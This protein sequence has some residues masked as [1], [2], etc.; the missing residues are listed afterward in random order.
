MFIDDLVTAGGKVYEVGGTVR[1]R[2]L[3][4]K[5]KD[6]DLLI[7]GLTIETISAILKPYG[8]VTLVGKSFGVIKFSPHKD[9][10]MTIDIAI[11]RKEISTG[12]GHRDFKVD[13]DPD[14]PV[15]EDLGR[16]DFTVN[17]MAYDLAEKNFIDPFNGSDDLQ[18]GILRQ[19]F[20][21][22]FV[23]DPLRLLRAIQFSA[24]FALEIEQQTKE[25]MKDHA[26]LINTV[27]GERIIEELK[28]LMYAKKPSAG[29]ELMSEVGLLQ[30]VLP[31][32]EAIKGI[33]Q[34]KQKNDDVFKHT[35][36]VLDATRMDQAIDHEGNMELMFA[37][38]LHDIGKARTKRYSPKDK[39][40]VFYGHQ[41]VSARMARKILNRLKSQTIGVDPKVVCKLIEHHMFETKSFF[42]DKAIRRFIS[43]VG[44]DLIYKLIDL[45]LADN[46]GGKYPNGIKGVMRLKKRVTEEINRKAPFGPKDLAVNG[47]DLMKLGVPEGPE[48]GKILCQLVDRVLDDPKL[49]TREQLIA[50]VRDILDNS[51]SN[52]V[53]SQSKN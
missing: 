3:K 2:L 16:R 26:E 41:I 30:H 15:E 44:K 29:F 21:N 20:E 4:R 45:R 48:I 28:K 14:I 37:A 53:G 9:K 8:K 52:D 39:R 27:S 22:S 12:T 19:V 42:S 17:A 18:R 51:K 34:A 38:L 25:A 13:Y 6:R 1:D 47:H 49:N 40:T 24:R 33:A 7:T 36:K 50:I 31:S 23:E 5:I 32:L 35:M 43:K 46:R 11:P 10:T